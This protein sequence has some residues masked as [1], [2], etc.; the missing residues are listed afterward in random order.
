MKLGRFGLAGVAMVA[1]A[2]LGGCATSQPQEARRYFWP[3]L[4]ERPRIEWLK[5]YSNQND[6]PKTGMKQL[7][8]DVLGEEEL[9]SFE[10][11]LDIVANSRK[12]V[13]IADPG[14]NNV[15]VYDFAKNIVHLLAKNDNPDDSLQQPVSLALADN[16]DIFVGDQGSKKITLF[17]AEGKKKFS[18]DLEPNL[19]S[20]G[21]MAVDKKGKK[22][23]VADTR[24]HKIGVYDLKGKFLSSFGSR[25]DADGLFNYP[26]PLRINHK[27]ELLVGD[28]MN[29]RI[30]VFDTNGKFLRTFGSR[31]DGPQ[32]LQ[33]LKGIA[34]DSEDNIYVTDGKAHKVVIYNSAGDFLL[35]FGGLYSSAG[36]GKESMGGFVLPQGIFI[37]PTNKIYIV[38]QINHRFQSFQYISDEH[39]KLNPI[40]GYPPV[41]KAKEVA[42]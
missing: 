14:K 9:I 18:I 15:V 12:Q 8:T 34:V 39:L 20:V 19:A 11:P 1:I 5:N 37:D 35:T 3:Q 25:G 22:L 29:A 40:A 41:P 21:G 33:V 31:G 7:V 42:Q 30:Q 27:N 17:D 13:L 16:D 26:N 6:L 23:F 4:P 2:A 38:D 36:T 32:D 24:G 10:R 28:T